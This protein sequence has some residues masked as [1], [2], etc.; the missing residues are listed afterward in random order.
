MLRALTIIAGLITVSLTPLG[1]LA[2]P[3]APL[4]KQVT[5]NGTEQM[6]V[7][8]VQYQDRW[9][10][11]YGAC[12]MGYDWNGRRCVAH[13]ACRAGWDWDGERCI[14]RN[15]RGY[16]ACPRGWNWNGERCVRWR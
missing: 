13:G 12:P 3:I 16:G 9:Y 14:R 5:V 15:E 2:M 8:P 7:Q 11:R 10:R 4:V 6:V 1:A